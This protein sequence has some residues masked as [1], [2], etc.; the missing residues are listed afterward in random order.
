MGKDEKKVEAE[1][2]D[3]IVVAP[4]AELGELASL[5]EVAREYERNAK[6]RN[7]RRAYAADWAAF[8]AWCDRKRVES[9]PATLGNVATYLSDL[10]AHG[11]DGRKLRASTITRALSG[12]VYYH[13]QN[14]FVL[15]VKHQ[16]LRDVLKG[17]R[18]DLK[19]APVQKTPIGDEE[20]VAIMGALGSTLF[21]LRDRAIICLGW[22]GAFRRSE[23]CALD[24]EDVAF[25]SE[26][27]VV[28]VKQS[29]TDQEGKG[30]YIGI[31]SAANPALC[32]VLAVRA[33]L[34]AA[35]H[36]DGALFRA[37]GVGCVGDRLEGRSVALIVKRA[38]LR[39]GLD[40]SKF[41]GHSL[42]S[43]LATTAAEH[44]VSLESIMRQGRW[45]SAEVALRYIRPATLFKN[46]A[47]KGLT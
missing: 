25:H 2:L 35:G 7:T 41:A 15:D 27:A 22:N 3:A 24:V 40:P 47:A 1:N 31:P 14:G 26:G 17:I 29:K 6:T 21:D 16:Q 37:V 12:I 38:A 42:R 5:V 19:V 10:A 11:R 44:G 43:G 8:Q 32:P 23:L 4:A 30:D 20:L 39:A 36:V 45:R 9:L 34:A 28:H 18:R 46:N 13:R 33:W